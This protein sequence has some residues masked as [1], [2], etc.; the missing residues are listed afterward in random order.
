MSSP[1]RPISEG[2]DTSA[3]SSFELLSINSNVKE[4][5]T[6]TVTMAEWVEVAADDV[7]EPIKI[8]TESNGTML[9]SSLT[10]KFP[11]VTGLKFR[12]P[13]TNLLVEVR[14]Q[15]N[16]LYPPD[17][18]KGWGTTTYICTRSPGAM[19]TVGKRSK[20]GGAGI[21]RK[22]EN[23]TDGML[24]KN[25]RVD[26]DN[27]SCKIFVAKL[28]ESITS[29]DMKEYFETFGTVTDVYI[30]QPFRKCAFITFSEELVKQS[31]F[32][33]DH[34]IKGNTVEIRPNKQLKSAFRTYFR[35]G[36]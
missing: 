7:D 29:E 1:T 19:L 11:E 27:T 5:K 15:E 16:V 21:K 25:Q 22:I 31:L 26:D 9:L 12:N 20:K 33:K 17:T 36:V 6:E 32:S 4:A 8:P 34:V 3:C 30:P 2:N 24:L 23:D 13:L 35:E 18:N 14:I 10:A 28:S